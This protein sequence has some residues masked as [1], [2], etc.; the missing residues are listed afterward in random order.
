MDYGLCPSDLKSA[1]RRYSEV[2][3]QLSLLR[4]TITV[5]AVVMGA[6]I[7]GAVPSGL[8]GQALAT[9]SLTG[10]AVDAQGNAI[11]GAKVT[12][13]GAALQVPQF[14]SVTDAEGYDSRSPRARCISR[15]ILGGRIPDLCSSRCPSYGGTD[16]EGGRQHED[17]RR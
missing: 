15:C 9:A 4:N 3:V 1:V 17:W 14:N 11:P 10:K 7:M 8:F 2:M 5:L 16:R 6:L 12:V 13:S